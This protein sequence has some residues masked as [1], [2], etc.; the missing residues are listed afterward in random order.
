MNPKTQ[1]ALTQFVESM[2]ITALIAALVSV[3]PML[4]GSSI[5]WQEIG[6]AFGLA[7]A[8]SVAH[9]IVAYMR[10]TQPDLS[11]ALDAILQVVEQRLQAQQPV[12]GPLVVVH[13]P[14]QPTQAPVA[15]VVVTTPAAMPA[16]PVQPTTVLPVMQNQ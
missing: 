10:P 9:S 8:V 6:L 14:A 16:P 3:T 11:A 12:Q 5:N 7:F 15:P 1:Q 13:Q 4:S 2:L